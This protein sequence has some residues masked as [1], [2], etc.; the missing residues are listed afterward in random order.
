MS[1]TVL[2]VGGGIGGIQASLDLAESGF[3]VYLIE[4][5]PSIGGTMAQL[6]K[7]FPTND[8]AMCIMSPKLVDCARHLN[9]TLLTCSEV[10]SCG[11]R[12]GDFIVTVKRRARYVDETRCTGCAECE[13]HCPVVVPNE[14]DIDMSLRHAIYR[15][16]PQASPNV[17][18]IEKNGIPPCR[19][20]CP[21]GC[22][23]QGYIALIGS[24]RFGEAL[25]VIRKTIPL[26][27][28]CGRVCGYCEAMCN[29]AS[30]DEALRIRLLKRFAADYERK[31]RIAG[32]KGKKAAVT[33][34]IYIRHEKGTGGVEDAD[35]GVEDADN[36]VKIAIIGSGPAGL[37]AARDCAV[38]G[39][40][41]VVFEAMKKPGGM[42]RYGIPGYRLPEDIL[43][44]EIDMII[45]EGV[46]IRTETPIGIGLTVAQLQ[47]RGFQ[48]VFIAIGT[49]K[50]NRLMIKGEDLAG[51]LPGIRFL[52]QRIA[53]G[54]S[55]DIRGKIVAVI[56]GGNTALD[57]ART[58][59]RL[60]ARRVMVI[61]RRTREQMPV[62]AEEYEAAVEEG[63]EF[64]FLLSPMEIAGRK[65]R[66]TGVLL[67]HMKL[68]TPDASGRRR[69]VPVPDSTAFFDADIVIPSPGQGVDETWPGAACE[70]LEMKGNLIRI[71]PLTL[72][73]NLEGVFAGGDAAGSG[74]YVVHAIAQGHEAA[75]SIDRYIRGEDMRAGRKKKRG[76]VAGIPPR[77]IEKKAAMKPDRLPGRERL[78]SFDEVEKGL[79]E[80][81][82]VEE[83][84]RCLNCS[85]CSECGQC[86]LHCS[87]K[88]IDYSQKDT[89]EDIRVGAILLAPGCERVDP[90]G[91]YRL[92]FGIYPDVITGIHFERMLSSSGPFA[93]HIRRPSD[94]M[95][96]EKIA[97][98][99]CAGSRDTVAGNEIC[100][101]VCCMYAI[102]EAVIA[103]EHDPEIQPVIFYMDIRAVG[104]DF[105]RYYERAKSE[106]N[107]RFVRSRVS[108]VLKRPGSGRLEVRYEG[109]DGKA[110]EEDVDLVVLSTGFT[111]GGRLRDIG[112]VFGLPVNRFG[113]LAADPLAAVET[114]IPG[115]FLCGPAQEPK[116]IPET[117]MQANAASAAAAEM[118]AGARWHDVVE[119]EYPPERDIGGEGVKIGVFVC[120]C[121]I[122]IAATV[123]V[124]AVLGYAETLPGVVFAEEN[125]YT[126]SQDTQDHMKEM[127]RAHGLN[128][129]VVASCTPRTHEPL[130]QETIREAG[131]NRHLFSMANIRDQ[132]SWIHMK[133]PAYATEKAKDLLRMAVARIGLVEPLPRIPLPVIREV[134]VVGG[135]P[136]GMSAAL[137]LSRQGFPV[138]LVEKETVLGGNLRNIGSTLEGTSVRDLLDDM[139]GAIESNPLV[140]VHSGF[141]VEEVGGFIGNYTTRIRSRYGEEFIEVRHGVAVIATGAVESKPEGYNYGS[142]GR[143]KTGLEFESYLAA[144]D[145]NSLPRNAVF[146][147]CV[148]SRESGHM[149][150]SR[151]CCKHTVKNALALKR[152]NP[153]ASVF[154]LYRDVRTYGFSEY[155]YRVARDAGIVFIRYEAAVKPAVLA[156]KDILVIEV[157]EAM[158]ENSIRI[159]AD[160]VIL[161]ARIDPGYDNETMSRL[162][163]V[164]LTADGFFL[165]AHVKLR[166]VDFATEGV[167][168]AGTAH[169]PKTTAESISQGRAAAARAA[170]IISKDTYEAEATI[171]A[172]NEDLCDGCGICVGVC[173]Y[174][175]IELVDLENDKKIV[176]LNEAMCKGCGGCVAACPS[177]AMEQ[178][179][180]RNSQIL[181]E[182]DAALQ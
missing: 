124:S 46:E 181:A 84:K 151:I 30:I 43:D 122:N 90:G 104:K 128:R 114:R 116:D 148:G 170:I 135:G 127:I 83:A 162:F 67:R 178:K 91:L 31:A 56:G 129:I 23:V 179:G 140:T 19:D 110:S 7:T 65:G 136:A 131:L 63:V 132:C 142:D 113:Y 118:L 17:F 94:G 150:C 48:A 141:V 80:E 2:V 160:A 121:G 15:P 29:R 32:R 133:E 50:S 87:V 41:P 78:M 164:P 27:G 55:L 25:D 37:T 21:A 73:T 149:Y 1:G 34:T 28:I 165:E 144:C 126:C 52:E 157:R 147:Q 99:Q 40:T 95:T 72:E 45:G 9:I 16:F 64:Y 10:V 26:P 156:G 59:L 145:D 79:T 18:A 172:L 51:V 58:A 13:G 107:V 96:P 57:A 22:N 75:I 167:F 175:A 108:D 138:H 168:L 152:R 70:N 20:A 109:G 153:D 171:A 169:S 36:G 98:I 93:G 174:N 89:Y 11:G 163:K 92:G 39:Y 81:E 38:M 120:R 166:P 106:Y 159:P 6:D 111:G 74:G 123:D 42:L 62:S 125:L 44:Y 115:L 12:A 60:G 71:D 154:V 24:G 14:F 103:K 102:K 86:E 49:Q 69:P 54:I 137:S 134:L 53:G 3:R 105:E 88:A 85:I 76:P 35:S 97:F 100:S 68:G 5:S 82:A 4:K 119:K 66:V 47:K 161:A 139:I 130:F 182:I 180:F 61:Y 177:G 143:I 117:I 112:G 176:K 33:R 101:S 146:I 155:D 8:C 173:S 77:Y 158:T